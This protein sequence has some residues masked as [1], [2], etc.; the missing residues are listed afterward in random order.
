MSLEV[1]ITMARDLLEKKPW[2]VLG[3]V[4][5][6]SAQPWLAVTRQVIELPDG[7]CID[8]YYQLHSASYVEVVPVDDQ[9]RVLVF[10]RYKHGT[11]CSSLGFPGGYIELGEAVDAAARRELQEECALQTRELSGLGSCTI[12]GNRGEAKVHFFVAWDCF[13]APVL[14]SDDLEVGEAFWISVRELQEHLDLGQ[15]RTLGAFAT[16]LRLLPLLEQRL[17]QRIK[18]ITKQGG[19]K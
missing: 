3:E 18:S 4:E 11:R 19:N 13:E 5:L 6:F 7:R 2:V 17:G 14:P 10:W 15:F 8:D 16:A 9:G 12:D 1:D